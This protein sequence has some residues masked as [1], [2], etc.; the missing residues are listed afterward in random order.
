M[1]V[2]IVVYKHCQECG[3][4]YVPKSARSPVRERP[5]PECNSTKV[6]IT[7]L[8]N[9]VHYDNGMCWGD[10]PPDECEFPDGYEKSCPILSKNS[11]EDRVLKEVIRLAVEEAMK[12]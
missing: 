12:E 5:C 7:A 4:T 6:E 2:R 8:P 11:D 9:C 3:H 1:R 10:V